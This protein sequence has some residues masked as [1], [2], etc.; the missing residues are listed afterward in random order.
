MP[1]AL[2]PGRPGQ[3]PLNPN[4]GWKILK[5]ADHLSIYSKT[6]QENSNVETMPS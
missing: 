3:M 5:K 6:I 4:H 2:K 1:A